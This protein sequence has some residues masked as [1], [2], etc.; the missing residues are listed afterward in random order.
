MSYLIAFSSSHLSPNNKP[1]TT[2]RKVT[3]ESNH[4]AIPSP[5][6]VSRTFPPTNLTAQWKCPPHP[7]LRHC[8]IAR[9]PICPNI[10]RPP[11][12]NHSSGYYPQGGPPQ[13]Y[14]P[15]YPQGGYQPQPGGYQPQPGGYQPQQM[16]FQ[17]QAPPK[18]EKSHGCLYTW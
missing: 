17:G 7:P 16:Q 15:Q 2:K 12:H 6:T 4:V 13:G 18:E 1:P 10:N 3:A 14:Q 11:A 8:S 5:A 9:R